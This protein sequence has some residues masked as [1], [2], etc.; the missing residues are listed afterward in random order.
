MNIKYIFMI[1][2]IMSYVYFLAS[3]D[4]STYIGST[5]DLDRRL[6]QHNKLLSGGAKATGIK[7][8]QGH[9]WSRVCYVSGFPD[10]SAALQFEW[11]WKNLTREVSPKIFPVKR[12]IIALK[13]LLSLERSTKKA[14][15]FS[16][17]EQPP[18]IIFEEGQEFAKQLFDEDK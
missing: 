16:E 9:E 4:N 13:K 3:T 14:I 5:I 1:I 17:W 11:K 7:V 15:L 6:K 10:W 12:R 2:I 18:E 8:A